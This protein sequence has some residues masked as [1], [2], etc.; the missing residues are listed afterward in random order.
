MAAD[1][2]GMSTV[3]LGDL[4]FVST[5]TAPDG[6]YGEME[7]T[8]PSGNGQKTTSEFGIG[9][10]GLASSILSKRGFGWLLEVEDIDDEAF[11]KPL[12]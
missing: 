5:E 12:L 7:N 11:D 6:M 2:E 8:D 4:S 10:D 1:P 3:E 9:A